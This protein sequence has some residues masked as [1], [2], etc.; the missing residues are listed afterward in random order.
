MNINMYAI[1]LLLR[2]CVFLFFSGKQFDHF[3]K[4]LVGNV[5]GI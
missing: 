2:Y 3:I 4:F 5:E 1:I